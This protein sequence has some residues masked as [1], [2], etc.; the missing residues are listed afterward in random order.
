MPISKGN[1]E[2]LRGPPPCIWAYLGNA[3]EY[4]MHETYGSRENTLNRAK[5][6][7]HKEL[8]IIQKSNKELY[9]VQ[10]AASLATVLLTCTPSIPRSDAQVHK[11]VL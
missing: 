7:T 10:L 11:A 1:E 2:P 4:F 3:I 9:P 6:P 5:N 8:K